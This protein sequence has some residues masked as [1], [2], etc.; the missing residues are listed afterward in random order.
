MKTACVGLNPEACENKASDGIQRLVV[1]GGL[2]MGDG[3]PVLRGTA[4][5]RIR[6]EDGNG[7]SL[8]V[9]DVNT[10]GVLV[11]QDDFELPGE[12]SSK[13]SVAA[14]MSVPIGI[15][16]C[17]LLL[18]VSNCIPLEVQGICHDPSHST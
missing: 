7:E 17:G 13:P 16:T 6:L 2:Q 12:Y 18:M 9:A 3:G 1:Q 8:L 5:G 14:P 11:G 10:G 15:P 4:F